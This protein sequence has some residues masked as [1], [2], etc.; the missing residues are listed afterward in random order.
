MKLRTLTRMFGLVLCLAGLAACREQTAGVGPGAAPTLT[1]TPRSTPLPAVPTAIPPGDEG[2]AIRMVIRPPGPKADAESAIEDFE[3]AVLGRSGIVI[4]VELVE[5]YAEALAALCESS[6]GQTSVAW[7]NAPTYVA[8][9]AQNCGAPALE[10]EQGTRREARTA[11]AGS[12]IVAADS[13]IRDVTGLRNKSW[14]R[15]GSEDFYSWLLPTLVLKA[16]SL[17]ITTAKSVTDYEDIPALVAAVAAGDC[18]AAGIPANALDAYAGA[19]GDAAEEITVLTTTIEFPYAVL[20]IPVEVP[21]GKRLALVNDL[22]AIAEDDTE[23]VIMRSLLAQN[24]LVPVNSDDLAEV[25][26]FMSS[27]GLDFAQLGN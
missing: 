13:N 24:A 22:A 26:S 3:A 14:C 15:L 10:V 4:Q 17:D 5:R 12:I 19:I 6:S 23:A 11:E 18:D 2:N 27:T 9:R 16:S 8:A 21:L 25:E 20:T 1:P 7:L